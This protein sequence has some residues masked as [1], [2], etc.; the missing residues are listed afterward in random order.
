MFI[1]TSF[2]IIINDI[3]LNHVLNLTFKEDKSG[4]WLYNI[5]NVR[6]RGVLHSSLYDFY[7]KNLSYFSNLI[8]FFY[9]SLLKN[10]ME[11]YNYFVE[12]FTFLKYF[13]HFSITSLIFPNWGIN[14]AS[15]SLLTF[16]FE[17]VRVLIY[18]SIIFNKFYLK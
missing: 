3:K 18:P 17:K 12:S 1:D 15:I 8:W 7:L 4:W 9:Y 5:F 11:F 2:G 13:L 10:F 16:F 6:K 14:L